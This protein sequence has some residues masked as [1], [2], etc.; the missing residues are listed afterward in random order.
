MKIRSRAPL[1]IG[2]AGGGTDVS[3]Y[4]DQYGGCVLNITI[5]MY[6]Y[7][8]I[9]PTSDGRIEFL[10]KDR[11]EFFTC[12]SSQS[13]LI[14]DDCLPLHKALY[15]KIKHLYC[16]ERELSFRM[17]TYSDASSGSGLGS[18]STMV[19]AMLRAYMEWLNLTLGDYDIAALAYEV[20]RLDLGLSGGGQDQFAAAFGGLNFIEFYDSRK[21][22]VNPL[23]IKK[24]V[25]NELENMLILFYMGTSRDSAT[26]INDQ[27]K[28]T[29]SRDSNSIANMHQLKDAAY[30]MKR[31]IL[32]G[33]INSLLNC[34][35]SS[36]HTKK[37][38]S[39][40]ISNS[41]IDDLYNFVMGNGALAAK[42]S[43]AGGGG[44]MMIFCDPCERYLLKEKLKSK[45]GQ[46]VTPSFTEKGV[47]AWRVD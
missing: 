26:I 23:R 34:L 24:W 5:D 45:C 20:E 30:E 15:N 40:L 13:K 28:I 42:I 29:N 16:C 17:T 3:P 12:S 27:I 33:D 41:K 7:C 39:T 11:N 38:T 43:G 32:R 22:I 14:I 36:W 46:V 21:V 18:S 9:E 10:S 44:F 1:R 8:T 31:A 4:C 37:K 2:L 47:Q 19:V 25:R 35:N 6:A